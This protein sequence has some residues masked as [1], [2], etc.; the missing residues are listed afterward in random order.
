MSEHRTRGRVRPAAGV[1]IRTDEPRPRVLLTLR[2]E[3]LT[4]ST[5]GGFLRRG[6]SAWDGAWRELEEEL[7]VAPRWLARARDGLV[8]EVA[9]PAWDYVTFVCVV[10]R[11]FRVEVRRGSGELWDARWLRATDAIPTR[12]HPG[13][14]GTWA[15]V[16]A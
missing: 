2:A 6:E 11:P 15:E 8:R 12:C 1:L 10:E 9:D 5:P 7:A 4:W 16:T 13:L 14:A 3:D